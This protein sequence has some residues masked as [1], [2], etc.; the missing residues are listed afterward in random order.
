M[1]NRTLMIGGLLMF[2]WKPNN[3]NTSDFDM[4]LVSGNWCNI[5]LCQDLNRCLLKL[6]RSYALQFYSLLDCD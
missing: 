1:K 4:D 3:D 5:D 2:S 6:N